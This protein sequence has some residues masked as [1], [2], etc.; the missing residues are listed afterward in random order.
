MSQWLYV[1]SNEAFK[2]LS[3]QLQVQLDQ[4]K[5]VEKSGCGCVQ[6]DGA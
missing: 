1:F 6:Q 3:T 5:Q 4:L 2:E